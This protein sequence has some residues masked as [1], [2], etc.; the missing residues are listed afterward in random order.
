MC[1]RR[2]RRVAVKLI[3]VGF[4]R[5]GNGEGK[6]EEWRVWGIKSSEDP[7]DSFLSTVL[8]LFLI[9]LVSTKLKQIQITWELPGFSNDL[10]TSLLLSLAPSQCCRHS[11]KEKNEP[12]K[13]ERAKSISLM[14]LNQLAAYILSKN[15]T[16]FASYPTIKLNHNPNFHTLFPGLGEQTLSLSRASYHFSPRVVLFFSFLLL[17][18]QKLF[19]SSRLIVVIRL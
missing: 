17:N 6:K 14:L 8:Q 4:E 12:Q 15:R 19:S 2:R 16:K 13:T 1:R 18:Q 7:Y 5:E 9:Q 11:I 10:A 3:W